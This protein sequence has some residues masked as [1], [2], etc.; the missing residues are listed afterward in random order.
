MARRSL[1]TAREN[2]ATATKNLAMTTRKKECLTVQNEGTGRLTKTDLGK[3][4]L[5]EP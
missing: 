5:R 1:A 2:M 3:A 4:R